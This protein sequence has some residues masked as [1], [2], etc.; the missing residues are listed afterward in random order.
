MKPSHPP[1]KAFVN[2][3][4]P[5]DIEAINAHF[6]AQARALNLHYDCRH[7]LHL[8]TGNNQ[9]SMEYPNDMLLN[10]AVETVALEDN[11]NLVFCKYFEVI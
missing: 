9:C 7:C 10:A 6:R 3:L 5:E 8:D 4:S 11:G 1:A 2:D